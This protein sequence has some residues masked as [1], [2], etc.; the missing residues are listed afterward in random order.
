M[1][2]QVSYIDIKNVI[3]GPKTTIENGILQINKEELISAIND[4]RFKSLEVNLAFPG[5]SCRISRLGDVIQPTV[6]LDDEAATFPGSLGAM[7][8]V[9]YGRTLKL[10]GVNV[11][12]TYDIAKPSSAILD[13]SGPGAEYTPFS[14]TINVVI[15]STPAEGVDK[16]NYV[17]ALKKASLTTAVYLAKAGK[18]CVPDEVEEFT[19]DRDNLNDADGN[20]L[21]RVV[22]IYQIFSHNRM[23]QSLFYGDGAISMLPTGVHPN[24]ILDGALVN[25]NYEQLQNGDATSIVQNHPIILEL[26]SRHGVD[27]NFAGVVLTNTPSSMVNKERNSLMAVKLAK[28]FLNADAV[29][30]T[31]EG[32]G[33]PQVDVALICD[34]SEVL[35]IKT[36]IA[37]TEF[38]NT[39]GTSD[40]A[41]LVKTSNATAI[42]SA[43]CLETLSLPGMDRIIGGL[44]IP[45]ISTPLSEPCRTYNRNIRGCMSQLCESY[46]TSKKY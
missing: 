8:Q 41:M 4:P 26:Y 13:M 35:G 25:A 21:P 3:F 28:Y 18:E 31:K 20:P 29:I 11:V 16:Y 30:I 2:L 19:L 32:G 46:Y 6:K 12:E 7:R 14:K 42:V 37:V 45:E 5:E 40:E 15:T 1:K 33:H 27:L 23:V 9:G 36:A 39:S 44:T 10:R 38:F 17:E 22:Y 34:K 43:G 24:E